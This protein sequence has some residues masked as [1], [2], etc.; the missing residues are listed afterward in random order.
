MSILLNNECRVIVQGMTGSQG[1]F[2]SERMRA[3]GTNILAGVAPGKGGDWAYGTPVFDSVRAAVQMTEANTSVIFVPPAY[4]ADAIYEAIDA[5]I[6]LIVCITEGLPVFDMIKVYNYVRRSSSR[7]IGPNC[8]GLLVPGM[9][10]NLGIMSG[11]IAL[12]G[13]V[14]VISRSGALMYD[15]VNSMTAA[16]IGQS[17]IIGIG[18]DPILGTNFV[19]ILDLFENDPE[20]EKIVLLGEIGGRAEIDAAEFIKSHMTKM[21]TAFVAGVSAPVERRMGHAGAVI[22]GGHGT[23]QEKIEALKWAGVR[24][25]DTP[26]DIPTLLR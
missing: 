7:L 11:D 21:V 10:V 13:K 1:L 4:A 23:A 25:A 12:P 5:G 18:G 22:E 3:Y 8:P 6:E 26:D 14:G 20:T 15:V 16:G 9:L 24:I 2:H 19:D 17:T